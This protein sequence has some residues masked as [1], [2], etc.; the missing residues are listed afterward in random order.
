MR[1]IKT[2]TGVAIGCRSVGRRVGALQQF[3]PLGEAHGPLIGAEV[4]ELLALRYDIPRRCVMS[5]GLMS[6]VLSP[7]TMLNIP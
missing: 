4:R 3:G 2:K 7:F 6:W 5:Q 1:E